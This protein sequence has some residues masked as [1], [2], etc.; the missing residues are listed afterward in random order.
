[1]QS[2]LRVLHVISSMSRLRGGPSVSLHNMLKALAR[3]GVTAE[4]AATDDDGRNARLHVP[5]D[6]F[7]E[8]EGQRVRY[9]PRQTAKYEF[10]APML[11]WLR[12]HIR[13]YDV[14]HTH[15][16]FG[17][18]PL[19]A[20]WCARGAGV[21]YIM[22]PA[23]VLDTWGLKNKSRFVK[24]LSLRLVEGPLLSSA[25]AVHFTTPL[26]Q[27]RAADLA[28]PIRPVVLPTGMDLDAPAQEALPPPAAPPVLD[29]KRV[30]LYLAR[31]HPVKRVDVLLRA[32]AA[33]NAGQSTALVIAGD[34]DAAL[35]E[36]LK[37]LA[38]ELGLGDSVHWVGFAE[39]ALKR[40]LLARAALLVLPSASEN[41]G[42][43]VVEAMNAG[44]P[45]VVTT[46]C[47]LAD[48]VTRH[49]AGIVIDGSVEAL[50]AALAG[51]LGNEDRRLAM[52]A[53]GRAAAQRE[54]S[55]DAFGARL[56]SLYRSVLSARAAGVEAEL[57]ALKS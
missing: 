6:R 39:G 51:L 37:R 30:I 47:G 5:L 2:S 45:V 21:P 12:V 40:W 9:F 54:L 22:R 23:G 24:A 14:V 36:S 43:A 48:F 35:V 34:G 11:R 52:G 15:G 17:F 26:E 57:P 28:L 25:A 13:E 27:A 8:D 20:A 49:G 44:R 41:F 1:M 4:V 42:M 16:L 46:G 32:Y 31:I 10:S 56:E 33:L 3:R 38:G 50:R 55:L 53:A 7:V 18:A 29:G 19:A